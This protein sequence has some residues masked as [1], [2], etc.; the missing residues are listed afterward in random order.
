MSAPSGSASPVDTAARAVLGA[1]A[2]VA[3]IAAAE[4]V[5]AL[6]HVRVHPVVA[7]AETIVERTPGPVADALIGLV[8]DA[9]KPLLVGGVLVVVVLVGALAGTLARRGSLWPTVLIGALAVLGALAAVGRPAAA[10]ADV[11]P[12]AVGGVVWLGALHLLVGP[13][14]GPRAPLSPAAATTGNTRRTVLVRAGGV[15]AAALVV[16]A[17]GRAVSRARDTVEATR[18]LVRLPVGR[19][20]VPDG[21]DVLHD[22][23]DA[24]AVP[25]RTPLDDFYRIDTALAVPT[26]DPEEWQLRIHGMVERE[27]VLGYD[28]LVS[29]GLEQAWLTLCC[30]SNPVGGD[31]VGNAW[32]GGVRVAE[33]LA[34]AGVRSGA[35]AVLQTSADGWT[36]ATPLDAL[37]DDRNALVALAMN[38]EPLPLEHGFPARMVVPGLYG[39]VSATKWLVDLEVTRF[40][41]VTAYWTER[42]W[43]ERGPVRTMSRIDVPRSGTRLPAGTVTVAGVAWAQHTGIAQVEVQLDGGPWVSAR[44]GGTPTETGRD[45]TWVQWRAEVDAPPGDHLVA[46]RATD[47]S[48]Y[49]QTS[50][51]RDVVPDGATGWH[52][53]DFVTE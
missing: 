27:I 8:G 33:L 1:L 36:C 6:L 20:R 13:L 21:A 25:W 7:V 28:D 51:R 52:Q 11:L 26:I 53:I 42:G 9:D 38:G 48:G 44:L 43:A 41:D 3:G 12:V 31:L 4:L 22:L 32:W 34:R 5:R 14:A 18:R 15:A 10:G 23:R 35:D 50:V 37:T 2:A 46:V 24:G 16:G 39:Y 45:D 17:V 30:V 29:M 49:T 19:G 40:A 47:R